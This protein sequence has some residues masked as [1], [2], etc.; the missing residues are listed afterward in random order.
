MTPSHSDLVIL[1]LAVIRITRLITT[2]TVFNSI[3]ERIWKRY[4]PSTGPGYLI[5][6][7]WCSS[8]YA[9]S[10]VVLMYR[11]APD[12]TIIGSTV[13]AMSMIAGIVLDRVG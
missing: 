10:L 13:L 8:I 11:I 1:S 3:R 7:N 12:Y 5:T 2:D 4:P 6:C 9:A